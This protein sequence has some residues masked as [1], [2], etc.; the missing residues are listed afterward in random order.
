MSAI[1]CACYFTIMLT[2]EIQYLNSEA[3]KLEDH[4]FIYLQ[5]VYKP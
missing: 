5:Y 4:T 1:M 3:S 2:M